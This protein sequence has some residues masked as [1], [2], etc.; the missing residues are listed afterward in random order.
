VAFWSRQGFY[1]SLASFFFT[2]PDGR[3]LLIGGCPGP[4][5]CLFSRSKPRLLYYFLSRN[6]RERPYNLRVPR[7]INP[8]A[9]YLF[10]RLNKTQQK[11]TDQRIARDARDTVMT[12]P[13]F[14]D[15]NREVVLATTSS[16]FLAFVPLKD[17]QDKSMQFAFDRVPKPQSGS[18]SSVF[19]VNN[20]QNN[21]KTAVTFVKLST[22][23]GSANR[24]NVTDQTWLARMGEP[25]PNSTNT[26]T[27][28]TPDGWRLELKYNRS[29][30]A[31]GINYAA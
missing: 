4:F 14:L 13:V 26:G 11:K 28:R 24:N 19:L 31:S 5:P 29:S 6:S 9:W 23:L 15:T 18:T 12:S 3:K 2:T 1:I 17:A 22:L 7:V 21:V 8:G 27:V 25:T 16:G 10:G 30:D 20:D